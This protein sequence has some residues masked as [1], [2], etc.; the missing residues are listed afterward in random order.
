MKKKIKKS[1]YITDILKSMLETQNKEI[2]GKTY[3]LKEAIA[4]TLIDKA[5][6]GDLAAIKYLTDRLDGKTIDYLELKKDKSGF[7]FGF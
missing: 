2:D 3:S 1:E 5:L 7:N 6:N 4:K